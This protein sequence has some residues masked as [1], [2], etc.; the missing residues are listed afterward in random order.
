MTYVPRHEAIFRYD[1]RFIGPALAAGGDVQGIV[2]EKAEQIYMFQLFTPEYCRMLIEECE[3]CGRWRTEADVE[4]NI[5]SGVVEHSLPDT[6]Q[7]LEHMPGL[8]EV[9]HEIVRR[10][11]EPL[12][13]GLWRT[14][15]LSKVSRPYVLRY[16]PDL[17]RSMDLHHDAETVTLVTYLNTEFEGGGTYFP[18]WGY[19]TGKPA[20]GTAIIYPGGLSHE[21]E[22]IAITAGVRYL[23]CGSFY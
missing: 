13:K 19:H 5:G 6:T 7:H 22:G 2:E 18:R 9:Y 15:E 10:H 16:S 17:V 20:P 14:F 4:V 23:M 12:M 21:H 3:H 11:L 8:E 1:P